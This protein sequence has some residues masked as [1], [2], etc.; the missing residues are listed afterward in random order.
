MWG[1]LLFLLSSTETLWQISDEKMRCTPRFQTA[2]LLLKECKKHSQHMSCLLLGFLLVFLVFLPWVLPSP[3]NL[4]AH[5]GTARPLATRTGQPVPS[6]LSPTE[7]PS[8]PQTALSSCLCDTDPPQ[9]PQNMARNEAADRGET[10][11]RSQ[12]GSSPRRVY[13]SPQASV[14]CPFPPEDSSQDACSSFHFGKVGK[15]FSNATVST[16][17]LPFCCCI[18]KITK[19]R[20]RIYPP[21]FIE[22][23]P[24]KRTVP[25][26]GGAIHSSGLEKTPDAQFKMGVCNTEGRS[27]WCQDHTRALGKWHTEAILLA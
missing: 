16:G 21:P 14:S 11:P 3:S 13:F 2:V 18:T 23:D 26:G 12:A 7:P 5:C 19:T 25:Y 4:D 9:G 20:A 8:P 6:A 17:L 1:W 10:S 22:T 24:T 27:S 15:D